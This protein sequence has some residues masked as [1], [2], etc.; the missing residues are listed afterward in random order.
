MRFFS[1]QFFRI[2]RKPGGQ[3]LVTKIVSL[4]I[5][6][7]GSLSPRRVKCIDLLERVQIMLPQEQKKQLRGN[8]K[9]EIAGLSSSKR[10]NLERMV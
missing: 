6:R 7:Y 10:R 2:T 8:N 9:Q 4:W 3:T 1:F 5:G